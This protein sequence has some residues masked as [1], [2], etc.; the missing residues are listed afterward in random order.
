M[1]EDYNEIDSIVSAWKVETTD[2]SARVAAAIGAPWHGRPAHESGAEPGLGD[3][4]VELRAMRRELNDLRRSTVV[5]QEEVIRL[6]Q[7]L[8]RRPSTRL[9]PFAPSEGLVRLS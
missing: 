6:R 7:E 3:V 8:S 4:M 5:L 9:T 1:N 2:I